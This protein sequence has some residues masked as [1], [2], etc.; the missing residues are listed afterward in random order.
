[1]K[2]AKTIL[3]FSLTF[4]LLLGGAGGVF[5]QNAQDDWL[6]LDEG[7]Q[8]KSTKTSKPKTSKIDYPSGAPSVLTDPSSRPGAQT[9]EPSSTMTIPNWNPPAATPQRNE[10]FIAP[11]AVDRLGGLY[12]LRGGPARGLAP[13]FAG[14]TVIQTG[15][16]PSSG[17]YYQP[18]TPGSSGS[19]SY[20][21]SGAPWQTPVINNSTSKDY[22]G[23]DGNPFQ[24]KSK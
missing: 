19:G 13:G 11:G 16:S 6:R 5:A 7:A 3:K 21:S 8:T 20:Y 22:W 9:V 1:M 4:A 24:K 2:E 12:G 23:P 17:N 14:P 10:V 15:P 18:S